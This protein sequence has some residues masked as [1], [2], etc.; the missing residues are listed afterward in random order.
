MLTAVACSNAD[1]SAVTTGPRTPL[2]LT[3]QWVK[4]APQSDHMSALFGTLTNESD[5]EVR[6]VSGSTSVAKKVE[7]H[8]I[9]EQ[10]GQTVMREVDG[11]FVV[12]ARGRLELK[13]GANHIM[14]M[15]LRQSIAAGQAVTIELRTTDGAH[16]TVTAL[17]RDFAGN[18]EEYQP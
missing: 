8:E 13:P 12:P 17:A 1:Q 4:A 10:G 7:M 5:D 16:L 18:Q 3:E 15:G 2:V 14:L 9:V 6:V 11:G